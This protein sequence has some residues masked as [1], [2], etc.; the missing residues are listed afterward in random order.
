MRSCFSVL[1]IRVSDQATDWFHVQIEVRNNRIRVFVNEAQTPALDVPSLNPGAK[2]GRI[3][4]M[5]GNN[6]NGDFANL[7]LKP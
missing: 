3:G 1:L 6:S 5:V 4:F 2:A 7:T